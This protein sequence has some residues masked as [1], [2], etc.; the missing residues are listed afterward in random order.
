MTL[1]IIPD[2]S[3]QQT[4][5]RSGQIDMIN[6]FSSVS[7][8]NAQELMDT[9]PEL[10]FMRKASS[11][12]GLILLD[13]KDRPFGPNGDEDALKVRKAAHMAIDFESLIEDYYEGKAQMVTSNN[14][15]SMGFEELLVENLPP[16]TREMFEYNPERA[17]EL[18]AEAGYPEGLKVTLTVGWEQELFSL[19]KAFW[20]E[21]GIE[22]EI[23]MM[24]SG[25]MYGK[26]YGF[27]LEDATYVAWGTSVEVGW[28]YSWRTNKVTGTETKMSGN[29][30][31]IYD[32]VINE[33]QI[34]LTDEMDYDKSLDLVVEMQLAHIAGAY[35]INMPLPYSYNFWQPG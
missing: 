8:L 11:A 26:L 22:T 27:T 23:D 30:N 20:D 34:R 32:P 5:L 18:L 12:S 13:M 25:A 3:T 10:E 28:R 33:I 31:D 24:D 29:F 21:V 14:S 2:V 9:N 19:I 1:L 35:E 16:E 17:R 15:P 4:A 7:Y 6:G